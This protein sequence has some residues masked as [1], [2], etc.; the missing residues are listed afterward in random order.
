MI[1]KF[2]MFEDNGELTTKENWAF[3]SY[4]EF[5]KDC[6]EIFAGP[7]S[8]MVWCARCGDEVSTEDKMF[9]CSCGYI[10]EFKALL[11]KGNYE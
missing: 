6:E 3:F 8:K 2:K 7:P 10:A 11:S 9:D 5:I 1:E 4:E